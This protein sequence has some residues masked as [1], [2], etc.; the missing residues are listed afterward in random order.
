[1]RKFHQHQQHQ[2]LLV[3]L[4]LVGLSL[5]EAGTVV[6][7]IRSPYSR[8]V[9]ASGHPLLMSFSQKSN[10]KVPVYN[11][12]RLRRS[13]R[14]CYYGPRPKG[15]APGTVEDNPIELRDEGNN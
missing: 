3:Y 5:R 15:G 11:Q 1:M 14:T 2:A 13:R 4:F 12:S 9:N 10:S 8:T 6:I 7:N